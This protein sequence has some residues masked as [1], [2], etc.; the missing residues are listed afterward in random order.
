MFKPWVR[1]ASALTALAAIAVPAPSMAQE[2]LIEEL[3]IE[4][5]LAREGVIALD[6]ADRDAAAAEV[7]MIGPLENPSLE[8][9]REGAGL[10][11]E[12]QLGIVQ[13]LNLSGQRGSLRDAARAE[14]EAV[15]SDIERRRQELVA[16]TRTAFIEC[17]A[18]GAALEIWRRYD[19]NLSEAERSATARAE[20]GDT[21]G[22]DVRRVRVE[23]RGADAQLAMAEGERQASCVALASLTG[24]ADPQ[25]HPSAMTSLASPEA[26]GERPDLAAQEQRLLAASQRASAARRARVP[27]VSL[28]AAVK[29]V[30]DGID[31]AYGPVL[32]VGVTLPIWN[33][34]GAAV[35]AA[36]ARERGLAAE[37]AIT[38]RRVEAEQ[39]AAGA[40]ALAARD[41]A[42]RAARAREDASRLGT[43]AETAYQAGE[44]G[45][46]ELLDAF[47]A[48]RDAELSVIALA[49]DAAIATIAFDLA[50][51]RR[52]P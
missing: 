28:G 16:E 35:S 37:L 33:G 10:E 15:D 1:P 23:A 6:E 11:N 32:S 18:A 2:Q 42:T 7:G 38:R 31:T 22:Y 36:E 5:A 21:A 47:E 29:R 49:R 45:V 13:P 3:A 27:Q 26:I 52:I 44:T 43:I 9:S 12:W 4:R 19:T 51:G 41:A 14:A 40:R 25:V 50:T 39:E 8:L 17:A 46:V 48:G 24:I 34:G 20:A 30:D